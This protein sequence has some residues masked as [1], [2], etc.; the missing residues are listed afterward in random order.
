MTAG[1]VYSDDLAP[2]AHL[3]RYPLYVAGQWVAACKCHYGKPIPRVE[4]TPKLRRD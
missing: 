2:G 1:L 3:I 4:L